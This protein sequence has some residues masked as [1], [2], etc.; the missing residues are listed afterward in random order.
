MPEKTISH[1]GCVLPILA[2]EISVYT[3]D[4]HVSYS[5]CGLPFYI[6][7]NFEDWHKLLVRSVDEFEKSGIQIHLRHKVTRILTQDKMITVKN[8]D[9]DEVEFVNYDKLVIAT[10]SSPFVPDIANINFIHLFHPCL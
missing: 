10:G 8:P 2:A 7:G 3:Q 1:E 4:T 9:T 6:E 5:A